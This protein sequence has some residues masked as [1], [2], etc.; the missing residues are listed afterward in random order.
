MYL[1][2][3]VG[4]FESRLRMVR[5]FGGQIHAQIISEMKAKKQAATGLITLCNNLYHLHRFYAQFF[6]TFSGVVTAMNQPIVD[7]L[8]VRNLLIS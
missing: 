6:K 7:K 3:S 4:D 1:L 2:C 8:K 5:S